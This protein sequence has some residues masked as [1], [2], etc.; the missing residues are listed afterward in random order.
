MSLEQYLTDEEMYVLYPAYLLSEASLASAREI[1]T[2]LASALPSN[3]FTIVLCLGQE[4][5]HDMRQRQGA[6]GAGSWMFPRSGLT[7]RMDGCSSWAASL[8]RWLTFFF[9]NCNYYPKGENS[10]TLVRM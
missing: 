6:Q 10:T 1:M 2:S 4:L 7:V 3:T 5:D 9:C 8:F